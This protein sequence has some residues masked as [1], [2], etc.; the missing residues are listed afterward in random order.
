MDF[1]VGKRTEYEKKKLKIEKFVRKNNLRSNTV[2]RKNNRLYFMNQKKMN[3][4]LPQKKYHFTIKL[5]VNG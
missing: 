2:E 1:T 3:F 5:N 4:I